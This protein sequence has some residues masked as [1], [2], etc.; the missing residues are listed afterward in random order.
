MITFAQT[1]SSG[2][3]FSFFSRETG[4]EYRKCLN[5]FL[6]A[7]HDALAP[8]SRASADGQ[9][10]SVNIWMINWKTCSQTF[11]PFLVIFA[12][13]IF[14][15]ITMITPRFREMRHTTW[16]FNTRRETVCNYVMSCWQREDPIETLPIYSM[17][18]TCELC[19]KHTKNN[20][21]FCA[22]FSSTFVIS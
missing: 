16:N 2:N 18:C 22:L 19:S 8:Y 10:G 13:S 15:L 3:L 12:S 6:I 20:S 4:W 1:E 7:G 21:S 5:V 9:I 11:H 14:L 17:K